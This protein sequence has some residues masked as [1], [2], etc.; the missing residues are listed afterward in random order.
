M[1]TLAQ[2]HQGVFAWMADRAAGRTARL[3]WPS[4]TWLG[5]DFQAGELEPVPVGPL[6]GGPSLEELRER[7]YLGAAVLAYL[8]EVGW[9]DPE[10]HA[11]QSKPEMLLSF[12]VEDLSPDPVAFDPERLDE[13]QAV[14]ALEL[15]PGELVDGTLPAWRTLLGGEPTPAQ[16]RD[17]EALAL[18]YGG[19]VHLLPDF[20]RVA[21]FY[22][23]APEGPGASV[24][25]EVDAWD[26]L[27]LEEALAELSEEEREAVATAVTGS[28]ETPG[29]AEV[30]AILGRETVLARLRR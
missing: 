16:R 2:A 3:P 10:E 5:L 9:R 30:L 14:F 12:R 23:T 19:E 8:A 25:L 7:G 21:G 1:V 27:P 29:L 17:L 11:L 13:V 18:L 20:P 28:P 6:V 26:S 22:A 24:R 4:L 15:T